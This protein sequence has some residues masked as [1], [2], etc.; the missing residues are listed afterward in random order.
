M[1]QR[2]VE[3]LRQEPYTDQADT[4]KPE[5]AAA[6]LMMEIVAADHQ[7]DPTEQKK[8]MLELVER[9]DLSERAAAELKDMASEHVDAA[10]ALDEYV[11]VVNESFDAQ[12]KYQLIRSLW[13]VAYADG[14][15]H[16][17][18]EH[19]IRRIADLIYVPHREF[20]RAKHDLGAPRAAD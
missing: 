5:L 10:I 15:L 11:R 18:E 13:R 8:V 9:F 7:D 16:H 6:V 17:Y 2:V 1:L 12:E 19:A 20:I 14:E 4:T 3:F